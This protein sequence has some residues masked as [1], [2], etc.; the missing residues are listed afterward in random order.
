M[1]SLIKIKKFPFALRAALCGLCIS[2]IPLAQADDTELTPKDFY[3]GAEL[4]VSAPSPF[5]RLTL[6]EEVYLDTVYPDLRDVRVFNSS[7]QPVTFALSQIDNDT[8]EQQNIPLRIFPMQMSA[9][10]PNENQQED[11]E[12]FTFKSAS[13]VE[14]KLYQDGE[15]K[16]EATYLLELNQ[17]KDKSE[18][19]G[20]NQIMLDWT[21]SN[22]NWQAKVT[23]YSSSDLKDWRKQADNAPLMDLTSGSDRLL[24]NNIDIDDNY[25]SRRARYWLLVINSDEKIAIPAISKAQGIVI[26]RSTAVET[27]EL[28]FKPETVSKTEAIY[29]LPRPQPLSSLSIVPEQSNTVLP[30]NIEYRSSEQDKWRPLTTAVVYQIHGDTGYRTSEPLAMNHL[31]V[32]GLRVKAVNGNWG[33]TLPK[34]VAQRERVDVL[35]NGQGNPPYLLA[36]G[37]NQG[38]EAT[39]GVNQLIPTSEMQPNGLQGL[40]QA[41]A[42]S[43]IVLGGEERLTATSPVERAQQ[44]QTWLLWG[45][46]IIGVAGLAL[47]VL[48]LARELMEPK[49][50]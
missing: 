45:L 21:Q 41:Y 24:L 37:A 10:K 3:K 48:R 6:P 1:M 47:V 40:P 49:G 36:W 23:L 7:G 34:A 26:T 29:Q 27:I 44:W 46:L 9:S 39:I 16:P 14:V 11:R 31:L 32:Q 50:K 43:A 5:Y 22:A 2:V 38:A 12:A 17:D 13:G 8:T 35:F 30:V 19:V 18:D 4:E 33:D 28:T 42:G 25:N 20:F 15:R